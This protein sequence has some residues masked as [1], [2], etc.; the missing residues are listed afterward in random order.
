[1]PISGTEYLLQPSFTPLPTSPVDLTD[2]P[3][4]A[5]F[6][7]LVALSHSQTQ[8]ALPTNPQTILTKK[9]DRLPVDLPFSFCP[10][11]SNPQSHSQDYSRSLMV[12]PLTVSL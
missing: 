11:R 5:S 4:L 10:S 1:M 7:Q 9:A 6:S 8:R 3:F 2:L 12:T